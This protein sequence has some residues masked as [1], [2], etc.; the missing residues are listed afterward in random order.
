[1]ETKNKCLSLSKARK[2]IEHFWP[3]EGFKEGKVLKLL[4]AHFRHIVDF[5]RLKCYQI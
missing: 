1:M 4:V 5:P 2:T 3:F